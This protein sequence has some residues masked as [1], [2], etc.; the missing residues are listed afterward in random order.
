MNAETK[1]YYAT[2]TQAGVKFA[3]K[4]NHQIGT[5]GH[6]QRV[7]SL[8]HRHARTYDWI[9]EVW[10]DTDL[11]ERPRQQARLEAKEEWLEARIRDLVEY[12]PQPDS[13]PWT[14]EFS[15]DPRGYTVR[16]VTVDGREYGIY[17]G[18]A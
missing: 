14:V 12:L 9:Q 5:T 17:E 13:G 10:C 2:V 1:N 11:S 3:W 6:I 18:N 4:L 15:G 16:L 7:C 8:L